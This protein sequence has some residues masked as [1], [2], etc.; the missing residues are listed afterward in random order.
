MF[1]V[2]LTGEEIDLVCE[3]LMRYRELLDSS[4][5]QL[6]LIDDGDADVDHFDKLFKARAKQSHQLFRKFASASGK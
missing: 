2:K 1:E 5:N 3:A 4:S 6:F